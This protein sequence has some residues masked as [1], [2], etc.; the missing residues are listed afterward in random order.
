[1]PVL[2]DYCQLFV[3]A[4]GYNIPN[5]AEHNDAT[6]R[7]VMPHVVAV[8]QESA[9]AQSIVSH[10][11]ERHDMRPM[12]RGVERWSDGVKALRDGADVVDILHRRV[13]AA[14]CMARVARSDV[15]TVVVQHA[16]GLAIRKH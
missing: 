3:G 16:A 5:G 12:S 10:R 13:I 7:C 8:H 1:M 14:L 6:L 9:P 15:C 2:H 4:A 11:C